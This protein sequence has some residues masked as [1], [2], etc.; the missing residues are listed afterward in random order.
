MYFI[1]HTILEDSVMKQFD[2]NQEPFSVIPSP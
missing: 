1:V 2:E